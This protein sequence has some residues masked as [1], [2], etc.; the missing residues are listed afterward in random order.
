M[1]FRAH[2]VIDFGIGCELTAT[3]VASPRFGG[4]EQR[5]A[6]AG[7]SDLGRHEPAFEKRDGTGVAT[8]RVRA[9]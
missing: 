8:L 9:Q 3:V 5:P 6:D 1:H 7:A 4:F 2:V